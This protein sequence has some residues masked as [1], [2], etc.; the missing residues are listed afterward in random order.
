MEE[1][2]F[3]ART[4]ID[5]ALRDR[6]WGTKDLTRNKKA[7]QRL[8]EQLQVY[9]HVP[10]V[11]EFLNRLHSDLSAIDSRQLHYMQRRYLDGCLFDHPGAMDEL[12]HRILLDPDALIYRKGGGRY[13]VRSGREGWIAIVEPEGT[14][15]SVYPDMGDD[16]GEA[17][18]TIDDLTR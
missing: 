7:T 15:V 6:R 10:E 4:A 5:R 11:E 13:Q 17:I 8:I 18:W 1:G 14:R 9:F 2:K 12:F 3:Q 16:F